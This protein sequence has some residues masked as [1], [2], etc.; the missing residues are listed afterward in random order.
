MLGEVS[1]V[2]PFSTLPARKTVSAGP[3]VTQYENLRP[4]AVSDNQLRQR[5]RRVDR[6]SCRCERAGGMFY[7]KGR[8]CEPSLK[9]LRQCDG[10]RTISAAIPRQIYGHCRS[11]L[12]E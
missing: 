4:D 10:R 8:G 9:G 3:G 6:L 1:A 11:V 2:F 5:A 12:G 7:P